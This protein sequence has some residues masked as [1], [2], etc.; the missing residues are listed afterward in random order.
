M[1]VRHCCWLATSILSVCE[2]CTTYDCVR[3]G[4][5]IHDVG[6]NVAT[7]VKKNGPHAFPSGR[8][9]VHT[10]VHGQQLAHFQGSRNQRITTLFVPESYLQPNQALV[11]N[12]TKLESRQRSGDMGAPQST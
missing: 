3:R 4:E 8:P 9:D 1:S 2:T 6:N 7:T 10:R 11:N 12:S 5:V